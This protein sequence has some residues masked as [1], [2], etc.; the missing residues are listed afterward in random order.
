MEG[1][2]VE[3]TD[4][5]IVLYL[6]FRKVMSLLRHMFDIYKGTG[7]QTCSFSKDGTYH[8]YF[9]KKGSCCQV[10]GNIYCVVRSKHCYDIMLLHVP[11]KVQ[12]PTDA[13]SATRNTRTSVLSHLQSTAIP[14][15][16]TSTEPTILVKNYRKSSTTITSTPLVPLFSTIEKTNPPSLDVNGSNGLL[17]WQ[18]LLKISV[19]ITVTFVCIAVCVGALRYK[20]Q[21]NA[22]KYRFVN[23]LRTNN[24]A[25]INV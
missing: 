9:C 25:N 15:I 20:K 5:P 6:M 11:R 22:R 12:K 17:N 13:F 19:P 7:S 1:Q 3:S 16:S 24:R 14:L 4:I 8:L 2:T 10:K 21:M 23:S 18:L